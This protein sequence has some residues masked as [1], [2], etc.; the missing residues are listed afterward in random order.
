[1]HAR[2][3]RRVLS[4]C[5]FQLDVRMLSGL[6]H[7][8]PKGKLKNIFQHLLFYYFSYLSVKCLC[9]ASAMSTFDFEL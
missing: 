3:A 4:F 7:L 2:C 9:F 5:A 8:Y 1:M 6:F